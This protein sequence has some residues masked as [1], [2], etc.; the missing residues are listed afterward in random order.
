MQE[1]HAGPSAKLNGVGEITPTK[2]NVNMRWQN[3]KL[4]VCH[5]PMTVR[6]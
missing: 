5:V 4:C 1:A 2:E 6:R 3:N